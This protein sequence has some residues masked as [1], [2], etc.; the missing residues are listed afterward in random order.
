LAEHRRQAVRAADEKVFDKLNLSDA[1]RAEIRKID[2]DYVHTLEA[3]NQL[4]TMANGGSSGH[5]A[6]LNAEQTRREAIGRLLDPDTLRAFDAAERSAMHDE[7]NQFRAKW[8]Q[9][10]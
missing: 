7:R 6:D 10:L 8:M 4:P 9:G 2:D 1:T 5:E 3:V